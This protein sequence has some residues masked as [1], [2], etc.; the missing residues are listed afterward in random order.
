MSSQS[1]DRNMERQ[2]QVPCPACQGSG[3]KTEFD[4]KGNPNGKKPC[5]ACSGTGKAYNA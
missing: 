3:T 2:K 5:P 4:A 1:P